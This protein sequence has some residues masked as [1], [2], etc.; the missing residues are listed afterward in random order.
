MKRTYIVLREV[1]VDT[2]WGD[3][4]LRLLGAGFV[5]LGFYEARQPREAKRI[6]GLEYNL[7]EGLV[8]VPSRYWSAS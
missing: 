8:A 1:P 5:V 3:R 6:A 7:S 4:S 2:H